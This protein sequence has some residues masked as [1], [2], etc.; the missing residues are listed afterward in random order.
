[1]KNIK[2][3]FCILLLCITNAFG[4]EEQTDSQKIQ[5]SKSKS[6]A[7]IS[8][9]EAQMAGGNFCVDTEEETVTF[10]HYKKEKQFSCLFNDLSTLQSLTPETT[11]SHPYEEYAWDKRHAKE[12]I[13]AIQLKRFNQFNNDPLYVMFQE[14]SQPLHSLLKKLEEMSEEEQQRFEETQ[15]SAKDFIESIKYR[16]FIIE[17]EQQLLA[18]EKSAQ[19]HDVRYSPGHIKFFALLK[20]IAAHKESFKRHSPKNFRQSINERY[21]QVLGS[22]IESMNKNLEFVGEHYKNHLA[23][24]NAL[25][26][27]DVKK[28]N[29]AS[30]KKTHLSYE[31]LRDI[32]SKGL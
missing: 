5:P 16:K 29:T 10:K 9:L 11:I 25:T 27:K 23:M 1:M 26:E 22:E 14:N 15:P 18:L 3:I 13:L 6:S 4:M 2:I 20:E 32:I 7:L 21:R 24:E 30:W 28:F 17:R 31:P 8:F 19:Q 12:I